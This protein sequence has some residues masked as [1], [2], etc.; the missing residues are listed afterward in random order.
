M[1]L[2]AGR[3]RE[4]AR[5]QAQGGLVGSQRFSQKDPGPRARLALVEPSRA[6]GGT[7]LT[8]RDPRPRKR[9]LKPTMDK[10]IGKASP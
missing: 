4:A 8:G 6:S 1:S 3:L 9:E 5:Q 2:I 10:R 7:A